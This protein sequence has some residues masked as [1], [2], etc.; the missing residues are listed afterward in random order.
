MKL[1]NIQTLQFSCLPFFM[2]IFGGH[3]ASDRILSWILKRSC[4]DSLSEL[5]EKHKH[6][7][8]D[9]NC[10]RQRNQV[11][12]SG[13]RLKEFD[14]GISE[15]PGNT[16]SPTFHRLK[17]KNYKKIWFCSCKLGMNEVNKDLYQPNITLYF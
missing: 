16:L 10:A 5:Q 17:L 4:F 14:I 15:S 12:S 1:L 11:E 6:K 9:H 8:S 7:R 13:V 3:S 2:K